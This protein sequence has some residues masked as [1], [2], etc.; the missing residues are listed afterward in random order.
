MKIF[1]KPIILSSL[2]LTT[3]FFIIFG[4]VINNSPE[5]KTVISEEYPYTLTEYENS[6]AI[7]D[8]KT[9]T[10]YMVLD[11]VFDELPEKDKTRLKNGIHTK[12]LEEA[13][14][15]AEDYE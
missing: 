5:N 10:P 4:A 2:I 1:I 7:I 9:N 6:I 3:A 12:T 13:L 11:V 8:S 14:S 15:L